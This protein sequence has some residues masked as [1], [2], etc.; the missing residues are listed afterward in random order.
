MASVRAGDTAASAVDPFSMT[1][2]SWCTWTPVAG[3]SVG[4][5][6]RFAP[7]ELQ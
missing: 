1:A 3:N 7:T 4:G 5:A 6:G 2:M